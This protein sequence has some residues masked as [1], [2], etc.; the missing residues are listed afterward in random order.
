MTSL[1]ALLSTVMA[2][3]QAHPLCDQV[4]VMETKEFSPHQFYFKIR[5][6]LG[7]NTRFQARVYH[8]RGHVDYAYQ[9]FADVPLLRWDNKEG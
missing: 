9:I 6:E 7:Q 2:I 1:A 3:L 8:N 5:A 4:K